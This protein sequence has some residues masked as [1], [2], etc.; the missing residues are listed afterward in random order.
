MKYFTLFPKT[1]LEI[2]NKKVV[3]VDLSIRFKLLDYLKNNQDTLIQLDYEIIEDKRPEQVSYELYNSYAYTWIILTLN[4]VYNIYED[5]V[6]PQNVL[7]KRMIKKYGSITNAMNTVVAWYD[8]NGYEVSSE[9]R[10][11][12]RKETAFQRIMKNNSSKKNIKVFTNISVQ[13]IQN[14]FQAVLKEV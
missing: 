7:D 13:R 8:V 9:S 14:D 5:W 11:R 12:Y 10:L 1:N 4:N 6:L 2:E 3:L